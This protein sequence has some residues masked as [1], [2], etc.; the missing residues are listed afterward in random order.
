MAN[1]RDRLT[2]VLALA[3]HPQTVPNEAMAAFRRARDL[4]KANPSLAHPPSPPPPKS[5]ATPAPEA[6]FSAN[7]T[8]V[9]PD[10]ILILV[11]SLSQRA[12]KLDLKHKIGFDFTQTLTSVQ[13]V[14]E[15]TQ[16]ACNSIEKHM[17]WIIGYINDKLAVKKS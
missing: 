2:K 13:L 4:V 14:C 11:G 6:T 15:G 9:H 16:D 17:H 5:P 12:Y 3:M 8:S 7:I 1:D 10:W